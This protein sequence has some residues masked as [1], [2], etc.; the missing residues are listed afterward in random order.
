MDQANIDSRIREILLEGCK[1]ELPFDDEREQERQKHIEIIIVHDTKVSLDLVDQVGL[2]LYNKSV[3]IKK[4]LALKHKQ[5]AALQKTSFGGEAELKIYSIMSDDFIHHDPHKTSN[6]LVK[7]IVTIDS[8]YPNSS[9]KLLQLN[10][11]AS[12]LLSCSHPLINLYDHQISDDASQDNLPL[13]KQ[14]IEMVLGLSGFQDAKTEQFINGHNL[15]L[16]TSVSPSWPIGQSDP[17]NPNNQNTTK[18]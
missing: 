12:Q 7:L 2:Y 10:A 14:S 17:I 16:I 6:G 11:K 1:Q 18:S 4:L 13:T 3:T 5:Q 15:T 8:C 9:F